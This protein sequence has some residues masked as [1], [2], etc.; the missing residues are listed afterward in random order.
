MQV[1]AAMSGCAQCA[2]FLSREHTCGLARW[3]HAPGVA[4]LT[5]IMWLQE[6]AWQ[7]G[8]HAPAP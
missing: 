7:W 2:R 4:Q 6:V 5:A 8:L 3:E 1:R